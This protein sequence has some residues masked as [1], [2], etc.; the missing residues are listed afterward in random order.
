MYDEVLKL[1]HGGHALKTFDYLR[2]HGLFRYLFPFTEQCL[3]GIVPNLPTLALRNTD[4]RIAE[5]KPVIPAFLF[6]CMLW[7]PVR[8]DAGKLMDQGQ[9]AARAWQLATADA[10]RDQ[11]QHVAIPRRLAI[12]IKDIW[13]LQTK[14]E[15]RP[16]RMIAR[17]MQHERFRAAYDFLTLR[18]EVGEI[19]RKVADWW[20]EIQEADP[21]RRE[22]MIRSLAPRSQ[23]SRKRRRRKSSA[24]NRMSRV[25]V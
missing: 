12:V 8:T 2:D 21:G 4:K 25:P 15:Q 11:A 19:E 6:A 18:A 14:L 20:T 5:G 23:K 13:S 22:H 17:L 16:P 10:I 3:D 24:A 1:F 9:P 7:D